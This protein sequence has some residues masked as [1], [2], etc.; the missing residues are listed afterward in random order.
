M[1]SCVESAKV[2]FPRTYS[3]SSQNLCSFTP[4][5]TSA[6]QC[7]LAS[8]PSCPQREGPLPSCLFLPR[9]SC[10]TL[11]N[12]TA[13]SAW[14]PGDHSF[15]RALCFLPYTVQGQQVLS[16]PPQPCLWMVCL[17]SQQRNWCRVREYPFLAS[18]RFPLFSSEAEE[19]NPLRSCLLLLGNSQAIVSEC[20]RPCH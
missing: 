2:A 14:Q 11:W 17:G 8:Q 10:G 9:E 20:C 18:T 5:R 6:T 4:P 16:C 1:S 15:L 3:W 12:I 13:H 7:P 19:R